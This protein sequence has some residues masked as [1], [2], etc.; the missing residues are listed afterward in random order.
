L[1]SV[2]VNQAA[3]PANPIDRLEEIAA[4]KAWRGERTTE[5]ELVVQRNGSWCDYRML[6][7]WHEPLGAVFFSCIFDLRI[8]ARRRSAAAELLALINERL[9][10][11]HFELNSDELVPNFRHTVLAR[12]EGDSAIDNLE[13][14]VD[15]A[16]AECERFYPAFQFMLWGGHGPRA[17]LDA[18]ML[19][20]VGEA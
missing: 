6:F 16:Y 10:L 17:A 11:G 9:W 14:L 18:A 15:I 3:A 2:V 1:P 19:E 13:E 7:A 12:G 4:A 8:P 5:H 20:T